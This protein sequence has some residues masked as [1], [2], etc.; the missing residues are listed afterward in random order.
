MTSLKPVESDNPRSLAEITTLGKARFD[1]FLTVFS[2]TVDSRRDAAAV[3][4]NICS[5]IVARMRIVSLPPDHP[6]NSMAMTV[7]TGRLILLYNVGWMLETNFQE[8]QTVL[9]HEVYHVVM[10]DVPAF[11]RRLAAQASD[12]DRVAAHRMLNVALDAA[13]NRLIVRR[14]PHMKFNDTRGWILPGPLGWADADVTSAEYW[15]TM[16]VKRRKLLSKAEELLSQAGGIGDAPTP[17]QDGA[18]H[19]DLVSWHIANQVQS[20]AHPWT[21]PTGGDTA[22]ELR[23]PSSAVGDLSDLSP[24]DLEAIANDAQIASDGAVKKALSSYQKSVGNLPHHWAKVLGELEAQGQVPWTRILRQ[25]V[26]SQ[27]G[28]ERMHTV[29]KSSRRNFVTHRPLD[30]GG[31]E[32]LELPL[33]VKPGSY[34]DLRHLIL[35]AIDTSGSMSNADVGEGLAELKKLKEEAP[36]LTILV[37]QCDTHISHV[38]ELEADTSVEDYIT[39]VGRTSGGGTS[40]KAPFAVAK[41]IRD[42]SNNPLPTSNFEHVFA[43]LR[44]KYDRVDMVVYHTDGYGHAPSAAYVEGMPTLWCIPANNGTEPSFEDDQP[45]GRI[46]RRT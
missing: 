27:V 6:V 3:D 45:F 1:Q 39:S 16:W 7:K 36:E 24:E 2:R 20:G 38:C 11:Y 32:E 44:T 9:L 30:D 35:F 19:D 26:G 25:L 17:G 34:R 12:D 18:T 22:D 33:P 14:N 8:W 21:N 46:V 43:D 37:M 15:E 5:R 41:H 4:L 23:D 31:W 10:R 13:N 42:P 40:F 29:N 28:G